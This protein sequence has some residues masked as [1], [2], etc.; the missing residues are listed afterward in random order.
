MWMEGD[1]MKTEIINRIK[2]IWGEQMAA[3]GFIWK[4][5]IWLHI[6]FEGGWYSAIIPR[7]TAQG[8]CLDFDYAVGTL[9]ELTPESIR[10]LHLCAG[11][12]AWDLCR[13]NDNR[14]RSGA[15][16]ASEEAIR[17]QLETYRTSIRPHLSRIRSME[18][19]VRFLTMRRWNGLPP[20][21]V[22][23]H[24]VSLWLYMEEPQEALRTVALIPEHVEKIKGLDMSA[25]E[26]NQATR[27]KIRNAELP[28]SNS[29]YT[30]RERAS[31]IAHCDR[32][33]EILRNR[34][35]DH[36]AALEKATE[37]EAIIRSGQYESITAE[38][39][40]QIRDNT[41][42]LICLFSQRERTVMTAEVMP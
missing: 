22:T 34:L 28:Y 12:P 41:D 1:S 9:D 37:L 2:N 24:Y 31:L 21:W 35:A 29:L 23:R 18:D 25:L 38:I 17:F 19:A 11:A 6:E 39:R 30:A 4:Y 40:R 5:R 14:P 13:N 42:R 32:D 15:N 16:D 7:T 10:E 33:A 27:E 36:E 26:E 20:Y 8:F 3:D